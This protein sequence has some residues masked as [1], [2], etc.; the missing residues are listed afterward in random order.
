M[1]R[2]DGG[3]PLVEVEHCDVV[4]ADRKALNDVTFALRS[5]E[6][7]ALLGP[8]G[9]GKTLLM[10]LLRG[11]VWPTPTGRESRGFW[12]DGELAADPPP[13][14][15]R[16]PYVGPER[17][18]RYERYDW[19]FSVR[20]V[21]TTGLC[22]EDYPLTRP[23]RAQ[24]VRIS[25]LLARFRLDALARRAFLSLSYGQR[26]L[27][28]VARALA[29]RSPY[30]LLDEVFNGLDA[31]MRARLMAALERPVP[32]ASWVL[33]AH[34]EQ[35]VPRTATHLVRLEAGRIVERRALRGGDLHR[36][37]RHA[38]RAE[39]TRAPA[40]ADDAAA[41]DAVPTP[42]VRIAQADVYRDYRP[43]F[44]SVGWT[45]EPGQ[46]WAIVGANGSGKS[47]LLR[48]IYGDLHPAL[49]GSIERC[50]VPPGTPIEEW[51][52][53]VGFLSAELQAEHVHAGTLEEV[54][55]SGLRAS[56]GLNEPPRAIERRRARRGLRQFGIDALRGRDTR[57][58]SYG[59]LR[60]ALLARAMVNEPRLLL[61]DEPCT[62]LDPAMRS[63]VLSLLDALARAGTQVVMAVHHAE[64]MIPAITHVLEIRRG[65]RVTMVKRPG[66]RTARV[67]SAHPVA[68]RPRSSA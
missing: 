38:V 33:S 12:Y 66:S 17:Q 21:V 49:G 41:E 2:R 40:R 26:R 39:E 35:D 6:R 56:V 5:G 62:G 16:V 23:D 59:Q 65:G 3:L 52:A 61:L 29:R 44:R 37:L 51:K 11:D 36:R 54:V 31:R 30:V 7:W 47:T 60:L 48:L 53:R 50:D 64:D 14:G 32:H 28:M 20:T 15:S 18:D 34:R 67:E 42:V 45:I 57:A 8:N 25:R 1:R 43:V 58:V 46:H 24:R 63:R 27:V 4:L 13:P 19:N 9:A 22:D 68:R 10:K 55:I